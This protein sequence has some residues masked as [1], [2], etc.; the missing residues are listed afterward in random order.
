MGIV[1]GLIVRR[2]GLKHQ[3]K[4]IKLRIDATRPS[5]R[6]ARPRQYSGARSRS[7]EE[8]VRVLERIVT[9]GG[10]DLATQIEALRDERRAGAIEHAPKPS[11]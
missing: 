7:C 11:G 5:E 6:R 2:S 8:R 9:D 10:Y 3:Q 4:M 1:A